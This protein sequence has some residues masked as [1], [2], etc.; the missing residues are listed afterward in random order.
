M[1]RIRHLV[2]G[3]VAEYALD[4]V[5]PK[6]ESDSPSICKKKQAKLKKGDIIGVERSLGYEHYGVYVGWNKVIHYTGESEIGRN[7]IIQK[8]SLDCFLKGSTSYFVLAFA[9]KKKTKKKPSVSAPKVNAKRT[10]VQD[11]V[12][13]LLLEFLGRSQHQLFSP[14]ETVQRAYSRLGEQNYSLMFNNC[15]HFAVWCKTGLNKSYQIKK[16]FAYLK[17]EWN[18]LE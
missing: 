4:K 9:A 16:L 11:N 10:I 12:I 14:E 5:F 17:K 7:A 2:L 8:T 15:E 13:P 1:K 18:E 6:D 3:T